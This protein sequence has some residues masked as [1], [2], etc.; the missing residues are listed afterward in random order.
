MFTVFALWVAGRGPRQAERAQMAIGLSAPVALV[1]LGFLLSYFIGGRVKPCPEC[2]GK[3][4]LAEGSPG[5]LP[6]S[7]GGGSAR[8]LQDAAIPVG[9]YSQPVR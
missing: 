7:L 6:T 2:G 9:E 4:V 5:G 3:G 8:A 1:G